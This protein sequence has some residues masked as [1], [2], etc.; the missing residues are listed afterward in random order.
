MTEFRIPEYLIPNSPIGGD[1]LKGDALKPPGIPECSSF[2][3]P[4][5]FEI[6]VMIGDLDFINRRI[7]A[8]WPSSSRFDPTCGRLD[9]LVSQRSYDLEQLGRLGLDATS[10]DRRLAELHTPHIAPEPILPHV[11]VPAPDDPA[12]LLGYHGIG[13]YSTNPLPEPEPDALFGFPK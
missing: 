3:S 7:E 5:E 2:A 10:I 11:P 8:F 9:E 12:A 13:P 1:F 6:A 4:R